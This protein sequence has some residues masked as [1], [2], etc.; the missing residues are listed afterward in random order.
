[1]RYWRK[2]GGL[3]ELEAT[4]HVSEAM[5]GVDSCLLPPWLVLL[6]SLDLTTA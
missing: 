6:L 2:L 4:S 3:L 1:M 5:E